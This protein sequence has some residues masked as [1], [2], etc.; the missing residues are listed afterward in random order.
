MVPSEGPDEFYTRCLDLP[1]Y[2]TY[3]IHQ[4]IPEFFNQRVYL[5]KT[6]PMDLYNQNIRG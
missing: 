3:G 1:S 4:E 6:I 2:S 5:E